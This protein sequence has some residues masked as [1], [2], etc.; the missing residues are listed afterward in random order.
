MPLWTGTAP[1][2]LAWRGRKRSGKAGPATVMRLKKK[3][4]LTPC[5]IQH[6]AKTPT[7]E[8]RVAKTRCGRSAC[9]DLRFCLQRRP[10]SRRGRTMRS[11]PVSNPWATSCGCRRKGPYPSVPQQVLYEAWP[12][13]LPTRP[14]IFNP[15]LYQPSHEAKRA[16]SS[17]TGRQRQIPHAV[18]LNLL[19]ACIVDFG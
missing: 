7:S 13:P 14:R 1:P 2:G 6:K 3:P 17:P 12:L 15:L 19:Q 8:V 9:K 10:S 4:R 16:K 18:R 5:S 11:R